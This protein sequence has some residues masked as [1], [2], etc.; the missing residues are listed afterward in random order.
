[1]RP[2]TT[3]Q[4]MT[5]TSA[6]G[7]H[8]VWSGSNE[9]CLPDGAEYARRV[10]QVAEAAAN[11]R[12]R[13]RSRL[14]ELLDW[15]A[16]GEFPPADGSVE[17][18]AQ[19]AERDAGVIA[20]TAFAVV[21]A[22]TDPDWIAAQLPADDLA[23]P[24]SA[25]FLH[26]LGLRLD[27]QAGSID[28]L[29]CATPLPGTPPRELMLSEVDPAQPGPPPGELSAAARAGGGPTPAVPIPAAQHARIARALRYRDDV[30]AW[31]TAGGVIVLGRGLA[32]RWE[33]AIEV[34]P[35]YRGAGLGRQLASAA[36]HLVPEGEVVWAQ[37]A[38]GNAASVRAFLSAGFRPIGAE[39]LL[40][41]AHS[42][43][44]AEPGRR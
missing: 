23:A 36:R 31:Q 18:L 16:T 40:S 27:R 41:P 25:R 3:N 42:Q 12:A 9:V 29:T 17:T 13:A 1:M 35:Q 44:A 4:G 15:A 39:V 37:I 21:F 24:L 26:E 19:P 34:D 30:R 2:L 11:D 22:D 32:D 6:P 7:S 28:M 33:T 14:A 5:D 20:L 43:A 8:E 38:P 10:T